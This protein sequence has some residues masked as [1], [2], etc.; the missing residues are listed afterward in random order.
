MI[1]FRAETKD[2]TWVLER[3]CPECGL[4][5]TTLTGPDVAPLSLRVAGAWAQALRADPAPARRRRPDR[6]STLEYGCHVRD[7]LIRADQRLGLMLDRDDPEFANWDQDAT[8][9]DD[10][11]DDQDP[12]AVAQAGVEAAEVVA[13]RLDA[14]SDDMWSRTGRRSDGSSFSVESFARYM[15]HDLVH[16]LWDIGHLADLGPGSAARQAPGTPPMPS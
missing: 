3:P 11:Y 9:V 2:W 4:D 10:R 14:V 15:V 12:R 5:T 1:G 13:A 16:H 7:V 8:A 6:W